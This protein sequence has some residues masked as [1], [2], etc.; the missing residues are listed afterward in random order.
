MKKSVPKVSVLVRYLK[1][2]LENHQPLQNFMVAGEISN[3]TRHASGHWYFTLKDSSAQLSCVM[4]SSSVNRCKVDVKNGDQV[5]VQGS[6]SVFENQGKLQLYVTNLQLDG[7]GDLYQQ[8]EELK[9]KLFDEGLFAEELK[10]EI[11]QYP[12]RIGLITGKNTAARED[13][14]STLERRWPI[15]EVVEINTLVQ[16]DGAAPQ[17]I[18]A[19]NKM[20]LESVDVILLVRGGGS[21]EDL[22]AFND[23]QLAKCIFHLNTPLISGVGHEVDVTIVDYV[24]DKRAPTPT[25]AAELATPSY[26]EVQ[27]HLQ[28]IYQQIQ[29]MGQQRLEFHRNELNQ[30]NNFMYFKNPEKLYQQKLLL[31]D[32]KRQQILHH[33]H[34]SLQKRQAVSEVINRFSMLLKEQIYQTKSEFIQSKETLSRLMEDRLQKQ[35]GKLGKTLELLDAYSPLKV[36]QR[37]YAVAYADEKV[38]S[39]LKDVHVGDSVRIL[40]NDGELLTQ[41][42]EKRKKS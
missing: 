4:F 36:L 26:I 10:K 15:A 35:K 39:T 22:W 37:G 7:I 16:G 27:R 41:V 30:T 21:L 23:E 8:F 38:V 33:V 19:L 9:K 32:M 3:L 25:G 28:S 13:V 18:D 29:K 2:M 17:M 40:I 14:L 34:Q 20:D 24:A 6:I 11:P 1:E 12:M 42:I 5:I 31:V